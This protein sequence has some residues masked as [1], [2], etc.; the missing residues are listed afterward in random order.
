VSEGAACLKKLLIG[1]APD[2]AFG[3]NPQVQRDGTYDGMP[4]A[5]GPCR[6]VTAPHTSGLISHLKYRAM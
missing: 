6:D 4:Y 2:D 1:L 3:T 5:F